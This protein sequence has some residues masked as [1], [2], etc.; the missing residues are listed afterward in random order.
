MTM[1]ISQSNNYGRTTQQMIMKVDYLLLRKWREL[2]LIPTVNHF[3]D[4]S[5]LVTKPSSLFDKENF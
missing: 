5:H 4:A 2:I 1:I 3:R